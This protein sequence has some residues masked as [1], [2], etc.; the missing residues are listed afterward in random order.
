M[1]EIKHLRKKLLETQSSLQLEAGETIPDED[2]VS[3]IS[4]LDGEIKA[5]TE[6][7][8]SEQTTP[9][10]LLIKQLTSIEAEISQYSSLLSYLDC[11]SALMEAPTSS[12]GLISITQLLSNIPPGL[13]LHSFASKLAIRVHTTLMDDLCL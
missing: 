3:R 7:L 13:E 1:I 6:A 12:E 2:P 10:T 8:A 5:A 9:P 4:R 11:L